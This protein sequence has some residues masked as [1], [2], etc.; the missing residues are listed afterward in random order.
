MSLFAE[1]IN[2]LPELVVALLPSLFRSI[3][4]VAQ[5]RDVLLLEDREGVQGCAE[6]E[7]AITAMAEADDQRLRPDLVAHAAA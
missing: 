7:L 4:P 5:E 2:A 6:R 3:Q 1:I